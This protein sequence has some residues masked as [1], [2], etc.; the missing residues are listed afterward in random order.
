MLVCKDI[1]KSTVDRTQKFILVNEHSEVLESSYIDK[2]DGKHIFCVPTQTNCA[3]ACRFC[4][5]RDMAGKIKSE[6][7]SARNMVE[8]VSTPLQ[9]LG[10]LASDRT[11]LVSFMGN[12]EPLDNIQEVINAMLDLR[13]QYAGKFKVVRFAVATMMPKKHFRYLV[14]LAEA[15]KH[16]GLNIKLH[17]S[18]HFTDDVVRREWMPMAEDIRASITMLE[19][20][21]DFTGNAIEVHYTP[22]DGVNDRVEDITV[23]HE[24]LFRRHIPIKF[25]KFAAHPDDKHQPST[26]IGPLAR[27]LNWAG[28]ETEFY[29]PPGRD[30]GSS[31]GMFLADYYLK[32]TGM[33]L[34]DTLVTIG[35]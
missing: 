19:W 3:M 25:L 34:K 35:N 17:L 6:D 13:D 15:A 33:N 23:L 30:I 1:I 2:N 12:G 16:W 26:N 7:L 21:H 10:D 4:F 32:Y 11:L 27:R 28:V 5:T 14:E 24:L 31:C 18:L 22:I 8:C 20:Y 9:H 29:D